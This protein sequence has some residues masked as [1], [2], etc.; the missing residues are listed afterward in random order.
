MVLSQALCLFRKLVWNGP[1]NWSRYGFIQF[2][3][4]FVTILNRITKTYGSEVLEMICVFEYRDQ[5]KEGVVKVLLDSLS[6]E[7]IVPVI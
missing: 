3:I 5:T 2:A 1:I 7:N 6:F 4:L